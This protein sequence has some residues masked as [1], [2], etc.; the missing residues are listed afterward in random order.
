MLK[1]KSLELRHPFFVPLWRRLGLVLLLGL[2]TLLEGFGGNSVYA[3]FV[4]C[5]AV[6]STCVFF[7]DFASTEGD[8]TKK[9]DF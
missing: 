4:G 1:L 2:W 8:G 9:D 3:F 7:F 5:V 6:Y